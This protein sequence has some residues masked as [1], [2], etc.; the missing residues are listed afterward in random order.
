MA[1]PELL[2][3][4]VP[5]EQA[6]NGDRRPGTRAQEEDR[7]GTDRSGRGE[8]RRKTPFWPVGRPT[9][10]RR[11]P[12]IRCVTPRASRMCPARG[13]AGPRRHSSHRRISERLP[14][15]SSASPRRPPPNAPRPACLF[16]AG[17]EHALRVVKSLQ[18]LVGPWAQSAEKG[19]A[20]GFGPP[21]MTGRRHERR[22]IEHPRKHPCRRWVAV[23][24]TCEGPAP[25]PRSRA[26]PSFR[27]SF[28][29]GSPAQPRRSPGTARG[30]EIVVDSKTSHFKPLRIRDA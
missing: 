18:R 30:E 7:S 6:C 16:G 23:R 26:F 19:A 14:S 25:S 21:G 11:R 9:P 2:A 5:G 1:A 22:G 8:E 29:P 13:S 28:W 4:E 15:C 17:L 27:R 3:D 20:A 10:R 24:E 12:S